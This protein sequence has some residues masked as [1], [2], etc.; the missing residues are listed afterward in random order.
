[1]AQ[2]CF[3]TN[4]FITFI[5]VSVAIIVYSITRVS[6]SNNDVPQCQKQ[7]IVKEKRSPSFLNPLKPP[8]KKVPGLRDIGIP[9]S[10]PTRG[11]YGEFQM[12]GYLHNDQDDEQVMPLMGRKIHS[13]QYEYYTFHHSNPSIKIPL[14]NNREIF[15]NDTLEIKSYPGVKFKV[16][17]YDSNSPKY[18][19]Y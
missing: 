3:D 10:V 11:E 18:I 9:V 19:P 2:I 7:V 1:M 6:F 8:V 14:K 15:D 17:I 4:L 12:M 16:S 13:N 5:V